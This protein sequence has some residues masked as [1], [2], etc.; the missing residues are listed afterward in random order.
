[1]CSAYFGVVAHIKNKIISICK[2]LN[3]CH[4]TLYNVRANIDN[5]FLIG[6]KNH[7]KGPVQVS[8]ANGPC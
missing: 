1:M 7:P 6:L 5:S 3:S 8:I 2:R 4:L